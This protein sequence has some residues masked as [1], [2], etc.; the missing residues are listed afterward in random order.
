MEGVHGGKGVV[1]VRHLRHGHR[2]RQSP[3]APDTPPTSRLE[4]PGR[5]RL[6]EMAPA[7]ST[8]TC[9]FNP[10]KPFSH[11]IQRFLEL[12]VRWV[13][14]RTERRTVSDSAKLSVG[15]KILSQNATPTEIPLKRELT[16]FSRDEQ[17]HCQ[18]APSATSG[19]AAC[20]AQRWWRRWS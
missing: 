3:A 13:T 12:T 17:G 4:R 8:P 15:K 9:G 5:R 20:G 11:P 6:G 18:D 7:R 14:D 2:C 10:T 1:G 19:S 16:H